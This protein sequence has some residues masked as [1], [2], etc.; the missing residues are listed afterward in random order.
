ML[1]LYYKELSKIIWSFCLENSL[2]KLKVLP[3]CVAVT[4]HCVNFFSQQGA[5]ENTRRKGCHHFFWCRACDQEMYVCMF[6]NIWTLWNLY[7]NLFFWSFGYILLIK[8]CLTSKLTEEKYI[9]LRLYDAT[10]DRRDK[11]EYE[12]EGGRRK[13]CT[14]FREHQNYEYQCVTYTAV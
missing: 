8:N 12:K 5:C 10:L 14:I 3:I 4:Y 2:I 6:F 13:T 7:F 9:I 1:F 11:E